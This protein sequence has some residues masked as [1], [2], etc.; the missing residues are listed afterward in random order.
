MGE[1]TLDMLTRRLDR[2]ERENRRWKVL[3]TIAW[4]ALTF[5]SLAA[6]NPVAVS[7]EVRAKR[8]LVIDGKGDVRGGLALL[9]DGTMTL[10]LTASTASKNVSGATLSSELAGGATLVFTDNTGKRRTVLHGGPEGAALYLIDK[11]ETARAM[12]VLRPDETVSLGLYDKSK[13]ARAGLSVTA[14]GTPVVLPSG[15]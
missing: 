6:A 12:L 14:E 7:D 1:P 11:N 8:F 10:T 15:R 3:G 5:V 9:A 2:L 13:K 4:T